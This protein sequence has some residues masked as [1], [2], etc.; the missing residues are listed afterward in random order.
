[1]DLLLDSHT[2]LWTLYTP[3]V[4]ASGLADIL[5]EP[6]NHLHIS[7]GSV[8]ELS[9]K[10]AKGRL[11]LAGNSVP[12]LMADI[13]ELGATLLPIER[14]DILASVALPP[15]HGD[16]FDRLYVAQAQARNLV[17]VSKDPEIAK[18][19]VRVLWK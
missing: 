15:H 11:P 7:E 1:M 18:Y 6:T 17:L 13:E 9:D 12:Q 8:W 10:A 2:L 16:P 4:L 14:A 19:D 5:Q 3:A